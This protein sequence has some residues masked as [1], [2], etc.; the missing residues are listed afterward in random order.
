PWIAQQS[1]RPRSILS[2]MR[3]QPHTFDVVGTGDVP[4][5]TLVK[6]FALV[7]VPLLAVYLLIPNPGLHPKGDHVDAL[8]NAV[9]AWNLGMRGMVILDGFEAATAP[10]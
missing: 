2:D 8:T 7:F 5:R 6:V 9:T 1:G 3:T 4:T 10:E